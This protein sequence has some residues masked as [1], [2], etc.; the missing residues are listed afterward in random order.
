M[1]YICPICGYDK[2][3]EPPYDE[4]NNPSYEI[5]PC[6]G[7]EY[8]FDDQDQNFDFIAYRENWLLSGA[9][10]FLPQEKPDNWDLS[11]QLKNLTSYNK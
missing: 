3:L 7:F 2:L 1:K 8:G 4:Y 11:A 5:C 6:C 9:K 10:W